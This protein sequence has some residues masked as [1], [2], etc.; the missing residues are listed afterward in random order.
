MRRGTWFSDVAGKKPGLSGRRAPGEAA[1]AGQGRGE[2]AEMRGCARAVLPSPQIR[3]VSGLL[4]CMERYVSQS[5]QVRPPSVT[6]ANTTTAKEDT[7]DLAI[8]IL[9]LWR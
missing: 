1:R 8:L 4:E 6:P 2:Q 3:G 7:S 5:M 9:P